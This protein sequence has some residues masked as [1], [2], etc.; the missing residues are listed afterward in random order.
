MRLLA[1]ALLEAVRKLFFVWVFSWW[2]RCWTGLSFSVD[3]A[4]LHDEDEIEGDGDV[5]NIELALVL[6]PVLELLGLFT[7]PLTLTDRKEFRFRSLY[8]AGR[9]GGGDF[10]SIEALRPLILLLLLLLCAKSLHRF[11]GC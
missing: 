10:V 1:L 2:V 9:S 5:L 8:M 11:S 3:E 6:K 7:E 4:V